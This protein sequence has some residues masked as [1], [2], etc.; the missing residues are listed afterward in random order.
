[1]CKLY[2]Q[3]AWK[4][5]LKF[6]TTAPIVGGGDTAHG[7]LPRPACPVGRSGSPPTGDIR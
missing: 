2:M 4:V 7:G 3:S 5:H 6:F 1:M